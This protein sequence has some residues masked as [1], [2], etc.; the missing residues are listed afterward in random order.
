MNSPRASFLLPVRD[1][2][3][4]VVEALGCLQEQTETNH[5][6]IV[7]DDGSTD[8]TVARVQVEARADPRI[9][10][11]RRP[12]RGIAAALNHGLAVARAPVLVRMDADDR[13]APDRLSL[14][15]EVMEK[16]P[17]IDIVG[18]RLEMFP[19]GAVSAGMRRYLAWQNALLDHEAMARER[20]VEAPL[21]HATCAFRR[22]VFAS[23]GG[24]NEGTVPEDIDLWLRLFAAGARFAKRPEVLYQW[25]E[26]PGRTTR[27]DPRFER[28]VILHCKARHLA[29]WLE[30]RA[31]AVWGRGVSR[32]RWE[33][34]LR[35]AGAHV[36]DG[37]EL[38][39]R[40]LR[41]AE[42]VPVPPMGRAGVL[43]MPFLAP[44][45]R[46]D[47]RDWL[48]AVGRHELVDFVFVS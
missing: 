12:R 41:A 11:H 39:P 24:W 31:A 20:F 13:C 15:L 26:G 37:G 27:T 22:D 3:T 2:A 34:A 46:R 38:D 8:D 44:G 5:E 33:R 1:G 21:A 28:G 10:L 16:S 17:E 23:A 14:L 32:L 43:V 29:D 42:P 35:G 9:A 47:L 45:V 48:T 19:A 6:I 30:G 36:R 18:S 40:R 4:T 7:I 25:R